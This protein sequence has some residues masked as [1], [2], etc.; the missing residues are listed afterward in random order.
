MRVYISGR[1]TGLD[2]DEIVKKFSRSE[3]YL[4]ENGHS[5]LNPAVTMHLMNTSGFSYDHFLVIDFAMLSVCDAIYMQKDWRDS[6]GARR[7][8]EYAERRGLKVLYEEPAER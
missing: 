7:E 6:N 8:L 4:V 2:S 5:V 3:R 1:M